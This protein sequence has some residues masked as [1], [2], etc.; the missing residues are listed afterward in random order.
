MA[1]SGY[2]PIELYYS[3]TPGNIPLATNLNP[4]E[5]ALNTA[6]GKMYFKN[7][8]GVVQNLAGLSGY[9]GISGYSGFSGTSGYSGAVGTSG[10]SG[11]SGAVGTSGFSGYSG[12][13]GTSGFSGYSGAVGTSGF[14]GYSGATGPTAY[15][16]AGIAV[17]TG[18]AWGTSLTAPAGAIVGTTDI[19][20][21]T[22][23]RITQRIV[24]ITSTSTITPTSDTADQYEVTALATT[25]TFASPSG[26]PTD[27]QKL[28]I[29]I[30]DSGAGQT[31]SWTT[32][33]GGYRIIGTTLPTSI[34]A[35]K[36]I[37]VGCVWNAVDTYWDV[38][39]VAIQA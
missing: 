22:N 10:F 11:Y 14:S 30:K 32:T 16:G 29:R 7:T 15:P 2:T 25:A 36:I 21:L 4:G 17:S 9:S 35:G 33:T 13:V 1:Q 31:I 8:S 5:L 37:Y 34:A 27:G 24:S 12:A 23:K 3:P 6:D 26:T 28:S 19:Q 38:L 20:T 39:A 18:S